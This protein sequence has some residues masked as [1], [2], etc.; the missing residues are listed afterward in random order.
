MDDTDR[1]LVAALRHDGRKSISDLAAA[2]DLSR[3]TVRARLDRL[4]E[5]GEIL[6]FAAVLPGDADAPPVQAVMMV[7]IEG[8]RAEAVARQIAGMREAR[9]VWTTNGRWDLVIT[10]GAEDLAGFDAAL[11]RIRLIEGVSATE[12]SL[13]L[14]ARKRP[15]Q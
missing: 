10:L 3:A 7:A 1:A 5:R 14:G 9:S 11:A 6:G 4:L 15:A 8:K 2:L 13:L 12:T